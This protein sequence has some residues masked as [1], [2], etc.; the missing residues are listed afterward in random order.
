MR[1]VP[2]LAFALIAAA[3]GAQTGAQGANEC[4]GCHRAL[5]ESRLSAPVAAFEEDVHRRSGFACVNCHGGDSSAKDK[6]RAKAPATSFQGAPRGAAQIAT[7][8]RCHSDAE[9]MRRFAPRQRVDQAAEYAISV[10]GK[11]LA[12]G[13]TKVATCASCH[14]AHGIRVASDAKSPVF[15]TNVAATCGACHASQ[16]HMA[17]YKRSDGAALSTT[18][19]ADYERSVHFNVLTKAND[20][21]APTCNDCHGNHGAA[22]PGIDAVANVCGTC[23]AVFATKFATSK[24]APLFGC[25]EC[26]SNHAVP[27]PSD[28]MLGTA[29]DSVCVT[30]HTDAEDA[31]F[32]A[33]AKMRA[34]IERLKK[35]VADAASLIERVAT[36]GMEVTDQEL[37]LGEARNRLVLA[38]TEV[39]GFDLAALEPVLAE[40]HTILG[41]VDRA[42]R[43]ALRELQFRKRGLAVSMIAILIVVV[44]LGI[45]IRQLDRR[46]GAGQGSA[47]GS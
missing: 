31:G 21:S 28:A 36:S 25:V 35:A 6:E 44:A 37:A 34:E 15:P 1:V 12:A 45:K 33:A 30:C 5:P 18:Q 16:S 47:S 23:H 2:C 17:G 29:S 27:A 10:H 22:P 24:H 11:Q 42:G 46:N 26:H 8:A 13:D 43:D 32:A 9:L 39:H 19:R 14:G 7:C 3:G 38:R 4:V 20:L 41:G 40:G